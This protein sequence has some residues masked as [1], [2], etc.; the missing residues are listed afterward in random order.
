MASESGMP[1]SQGPERRQ[2]GDSG[3]RGSGGSSQAA[4]RPRQRASRRRKI[5]TWTSGLAAAAVAA[6]AVTLYLGYRHLNG[7]IRVRNVGRLVGTQPTAPHP[8]AQNILVLGSDSRAGTNGQYGNAHVYATAHSDTLMIVHIAA[9][10]RWAEVVSIPRDSW[11]HIPSCDMGN[12]HRSAPADFKINESFTLGSLHGDQASGAACT[13]RT[14]ERNTGL[15]IDHFVAINFAGFKDMVNALGGVE[16]CTR[17]PIAD[18]KAKLYLPA[19]HHLLSGGPALAY[20]RA[21]YS[22]GD[23]S[24]LGR[25]GRQQAFMSSLAERAKSELY[26][27]VAIYRFL[28]AATKSISIDSGLGGIHGLYDLANRLRS[29]PTGNIRFITLPTSPRSLIDPSDTANVVWLQPEA[30]EIFVSLRDDAPWAI[31]PPARTAAHEP[32]PT[33]RAAGRLAGATPAPRS[34]NVPVRTASQNTCT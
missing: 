2:P 23:G 10:R 11:V 19:G 25:I 34:P 3:H 28:D 4:P 14:V 26:N 7:N 8:R 27:P 31:K 33:A 1:S 13:I 32:A 22:L 18:Q 16:V 29:M 24:D 15:R 20:V 21:R 9:N 12:G 6:G 17:Q 5:L 30:G